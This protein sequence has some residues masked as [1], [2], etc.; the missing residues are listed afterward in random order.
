MA[1]LEGV[2][3]TFDSPVKPNAYVLAP[4]K[5][6]GTFI[7]PDLQKFV[8]G[9]EK[10]NWKVGGINFKG[11][12]KGLLIQD[13]IDAL[14]GSMLVESHNPVFTAGL[15]EYNRSDHEMTTFLSYWAYEEAKHYGVLR[16]YLE[17]TE[18][19][20]PNELEDMLRETRAGVWGEEETSWT[21]V[22]T[23]T[24]TTL[25]EIT[26]HIFYKR[27]AERTKEPVLKGMLADLGKDEMRH[28]QWYLKKAKQTLGEDRG[29]RL[30]E[31]D[32]ILLRFRMPGTTFVP[33]Y[34]KHEAAMIKAAAPGINEKRQVLGTITNIVGP[35]HATKLIATGAYK[36][37]LDQ[38]EKAA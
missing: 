13:D 29:H 35:I 28:C 14:L 19:V 27:F 32:Q 3:S 4:G 23:L 7:T 37:K 20:N 22:Q 38:W 33:D 8:E 30:E 6:V 26:T 36:K 10:M 34:P 18:M 5:E 25:Q 2:G 12:Q 24:Y 17:A 1:L 31:V 9:H 11:I 15:M 21:Q 16:T